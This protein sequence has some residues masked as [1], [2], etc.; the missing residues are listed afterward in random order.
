MRNAEAGAL[1]RHRRFPAAATGDRWRFERNGAGRGKRGNRFLSLSLCRIETRTAHRI[2]SIDADRSPRIGAGTNRPSNGAGTPLAVPGAGGEEKTRDAWDPT[3]R[4]RNAAAEKL[5]RPAVLYMCGARTEPNRARAEAK[6]ERV[7][8]V[9]VAALSKTHGTTTTPIASTRSSTTTCP[10]FCAHPGPAGLEHRDG[11]TRLK[12][13]AK[14]KHAS[15]C[16]RRLSR[17]I[18][19]NLGRDLFF[20]TGTTTGTPRFIRHDHLLRRWY[21]GR[22]DVGNM[23]ETESCVVWS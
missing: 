20:G 1:E 21:Y 8:V 2:A 7:V 3:H 14:K 13:R 22:S 17:G 9:P 10:W 12:N 19:W 18:L 23:E 4:G 5:P 15:W 16:M 6:Q 11:G